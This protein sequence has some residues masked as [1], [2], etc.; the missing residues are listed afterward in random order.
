MD[1]EEESKKE[2]DF[3][4]EC[5]EIAKNAPEELASHFN[6]YLG[7]E[8]EA[9]TKSIDTLINMVIETKSENAQLKAEIDKLKDQIHSGYRG[10]S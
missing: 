6:F 7:E 5:I 10:N 4:N 9:R 1:L 2:L 8:N 3:L